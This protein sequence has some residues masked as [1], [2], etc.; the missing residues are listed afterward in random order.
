MS[1]HKE[2]IVS[3]TAVGA[4]VLL[5]VM[6]FTFDKPQAA[7]ESIIPECTPECGGECYEERYQCAP[8]TLSPGH[9]PNDDYQL[10]VADEKLIPMTALE[11]SIWMQESS[12]RE[13]PIMGKKGE[14]GALQ[15]R[16]C[17]WLDALEYDP[18]IG[19]EYEDVDTIEYSL[20]IFRAYTARYGVPKRIGDMNP[21]EAKARIWNGGP[22]GHKKKATLHYW[23][24]IKSRL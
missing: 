12:G 6:T 15:I 23:N 1:K 3:V 10:H 17:A 4:S 24:D 19:G 14:R 18:S 22:S 13:G 21:N 8:V 11:Y 7:A 20:A 16:E 5:T 2:L 9:T